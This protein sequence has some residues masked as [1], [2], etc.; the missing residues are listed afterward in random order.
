MLMASHALRRL[1]LPERWLVGLAAALGL[2]L[3][4]WTLALMDVGA[5]TGDFFGVVLGLAIAGTFLALPVLP[6]AVIVIAAAAWSRNAFSRVVLGIALLAAA[7]LAAWGYPA[8]DDDAQ[9]GVLIIAI[10]VMQ[11]PI[12]AVAAGLSAAFGRR[13]TA[14]ST[15]A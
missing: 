9:G 3:L 2:A 10:P 7:G 5:L 13:G 6:F 1:P 15:A 12:V 11:L 14:R 8:V 4:L